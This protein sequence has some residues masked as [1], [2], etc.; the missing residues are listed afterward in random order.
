MTSLLTN[1]TIY[2]MS[3]DLSMKLPELIVNLTV[4]GLLRS[5]ITSEVTCTVAV[6]ENVYWYNQFVLILAYGS[7]GLFVGNRA[8]YVNGGPTGGIYLFLSF[9]RHAIPLWTNCAKGTEYELL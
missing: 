8:T 1:T 9:E 4:S 6:D 2:A 7:T 3:T 5:N